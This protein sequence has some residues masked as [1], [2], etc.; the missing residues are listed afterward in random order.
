MKFKHL[1]FLIPIAILVTFYLK[2]SKANIQGNFVR[3]FISDTSFHQSMTLD[4]KG[5][6]DGFCI[7]NENLWINRKFEIVK[8]NKDSNKE[9]K[10][11]TTA[12]IS[13]NAPIQEFYVENDSVYFSQPN[14]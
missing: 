14:N 12:T 10:L 9:V 4:I 8:Y 1:L 11:K 5:I 6:V 2:T 13:N 7:D 3:T